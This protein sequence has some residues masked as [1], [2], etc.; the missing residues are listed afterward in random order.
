MTKNQT[1]TLIAAAILCT[2]LTG[3]GTIPSYEDLGNGYVEATYTRTSWEPPASRSEL[4][5][6]SGWKKIQIWPDTLG[7]CVKNGVALFTGYAASRQPNSENH[8]NTEPRLFAVRAPD[9]P[10]DITGEVLWRWSKQSGNDFAKI[11]PNTHVFWEEK[12][13][14][15]EFS[16]AIDWNKDVGFRLDWNQISDVMREVKEK[17][18]VRKDRVWGTSYIEKEFKPETT[19]K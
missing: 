4:C 14:A 16:F 7:V 2:N 9:L 8:R 13:K 5:Y 11:N 6:K 17:G 12:E 19:G 18:V 3:C 10:L 15:V 1:L